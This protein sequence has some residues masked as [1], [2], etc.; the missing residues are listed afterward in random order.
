MSERLVRPATSSLSLDEVIVRITRHGEVEGVVLVGS[1]AT[2]ELSPAS[3]YDIMVVLAPGGTGF[4]VEVTAIDGRLTDVLVVDLEVLEGASTG[5]DELDR[6]IA[7]WLTTGRVVF[8]RNG[9][10]Q[11]ART[12]SEIP[13]VPEPLGEA[14]AS[15]ERWQVSYDLLVNENYARSE[16][17]VYVLGLRLRA[18]HSFSRLLLA[19]FRVRGLVWQ[20]ENWAI[21]HL[22]E[23]D[24]PF[25][26]VVNQWL[27]AAHPSDQLE[28]HR[29]AAER[30]LEPVGGVWPRGAFP[31]GEGVWERLTRT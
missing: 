13:S 3:D 4:H 22:A 29:I 16:E 14:T 11:T 6:R 15:A 5:P 1:T 25:L 18:L 20:G 2:G 26:D 21:R 8:D 31:I 7:N 19:Y 30:A 23:H 24:R 12:R 10:V 17:L 27:D 9:A 28:V